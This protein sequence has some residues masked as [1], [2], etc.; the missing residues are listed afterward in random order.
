MQGQYD[1]IVLGAG[2]AGR[3]AAVIARRS[4]LNVLVIEKD[5][6][7]GTCPLRGCIPKKVLV[8]ATQALEHARVLP[9]ALTGAENLRIDWP[10]LMRLKHAIIKDTPENVRKNLLAQDIDVLEARARFSG[11]HTVIADGKEF[12]GRKLIIA[13][14]SKPRSLPIKGFEHTLTSDMLLEIQTPPASII[15]IG[16]GPIGMEFGHV[17]ARTGTKVTILEAAPRILPALDKDLTERLALASRRLGIEIYTG[18][19]IE[20]IERPTHA[21]AVTFSHGGFTKSVLAE[22]AAGGAGRVADI[23]DL[24]L[25]TAGIERDGR[26]IVTD[27]FLRTSNPDV[28]VAGD[29]VAASPQLSEVAAYEGKLAARNLFA[30]AMTPARYDSV[31]FVVYTIPEIAGVGLLPDE[32]LAG[33]HRVSMLDLTGLKTSRTYGES[34]SLSKVVIEEG[35]GKIMGAHILGHRGE[36]LIN[37]FSLAVRFGLTVHDLNNAVFSFPSFSADIKDMLKG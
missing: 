29:A 15:F 22:A 13:T 11:T 25:Q 4:G 21:L 37:I 10:A 9:A 28:F 16:A 20:A 34:L 36:E 24:D 18:V 17:L 3:A 23:D 14:G 12:E 8:A 33:K 19:L 30:E 2:P 1:V 32:A 26:G 5:G 27:A 6:F 35:T 7:G 31:P